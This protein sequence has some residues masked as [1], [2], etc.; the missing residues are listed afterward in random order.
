[1][2]TAD[3]DQPVD[4][5]RFVTYVSLSLRRY[6]ARW[7]RTLAVRSRRELAVL[8]APADED[9]E[10]RSVAG[11]SALT[12]PSAEDELLTALPLE[13]VLLDARLYRNYRRLTPRERFALACLVIEG[14]RQSLLAQRL[15]ISQQAV[16]SNKE[17]ALR[18][19]RSSFD[20][21]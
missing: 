17:R 13:D 20:E 7:R 12:T 11:L 5:R 16:N 1:M 3:T 4:D 15:G 8:D 9:V 14:E 18:R 10:G 21:R 2:K 6:A 19:L